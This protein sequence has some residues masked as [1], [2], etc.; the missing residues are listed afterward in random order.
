MIVVVDIPKDA[1]M[2][3]L[4]IEGGRIIMR[5]ATTSHFAKAVSVRTAR[6]ETLEEFDSEMQGDKAMPFQ[7]SKDIFVT[8]AGGITTG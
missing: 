1:E 6:V 8:G 2:E 5:A 7:S 3:I 4:R